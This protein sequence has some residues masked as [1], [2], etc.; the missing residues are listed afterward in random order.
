MLTGY[1]KVPM[2]E[3][4]NKL[5]LGNKLDDAIKRPANK[6]VQGN[7]SVKQMGEL[8]VSKFRGHDLSNA[9][10]GKRVVNISPLIL[11]KILQHS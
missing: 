2:D 3:L 8:L 10:A 9:E 7:V 11:Y 5:V 1:N 6:D 4:R